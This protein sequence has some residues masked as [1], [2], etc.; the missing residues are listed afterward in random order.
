MEGCFSQEFPGSE[1]DFLYHSDGQ[2]IKV[3]DVH[4]EILVL[5]EMLCAIS[6]SGG[7]S[8]QKIIGAAPSGP[9]RVSHRADQ[10]VHSASSSDYIVI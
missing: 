8:F 4:L 2:R 1:L 5:A 9:L 6:S 10:N 3:I 7:I